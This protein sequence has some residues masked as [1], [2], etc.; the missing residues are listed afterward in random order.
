MRYRNAHSGLSMRQSSL[1]GRQNRARN[2]A[3]RGAASAAQAQGPS[4]AWPLAPTAAQSSA[5]TRCARCS[6]AQSRSE[7]ASAEGSRARSA[8]SRS[9]GHRP[10]AS[11]ARCSSRTSA[12]R[13]G[14][15]TKRRRR[16][17]TARPRPSRP[18]HS[19][20]SS[21]RVA[22]GSASTPAQANTASRTVSVF[23]TMLTTLSKHRLR[24]T[25]R[26]KVFTS[27]N[28]PARQL[29]V[30]AWCC[31]NFC[32]TFP[33]SR[34]VSGS[35]EEHATRWHASAASDQAAPAISSFPCRE[36][37]S[38][39]TARSCSSMSL[40]MQVP[41]EAASLLAALPPLSVPSSNAR[42]RAV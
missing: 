11:K 6:S 8:A 3:M 4:R 2:H 12:V 10:V 17:H 36:S 25:R 15:R 29:P 22:S 5:S 27:S 31:S 39:I 32:K 18:V 40:G 21:S 9:S 28:T 19:P 33:A 16:K 23:S 24:A 1:S 14:P 37:R 34:A 35:E 26:W 30:D 7:R 42:T 38:A 13:R 20:G 41:V